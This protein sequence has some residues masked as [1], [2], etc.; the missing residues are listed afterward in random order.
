[1]DTTSPLIWRE[2]GSNQDTGQSWG[3]LEPNPYY[4]PP[5]V[6][7]APPDPLGVWEVNPAGDYRRRRISWDEPVGSGDMFQLV[8]HAGDDR[9]KVFWRG[10][11]AMHQYTFEKFD[12]ASGTWKLFDPGEHDE[13]ARYLWAGVIAPSHTLAVSALAAGTA[14]AQQ[15]LDLLHPDIAGQISQRGWNAA[16]FQ[17][18]DILASPT[19]AKDAAALGI[20][21]TPEQIAA[22]RA[23]LAATTP[24]AQAAAA[25]SGGLGVLGLVVAAVAIAMLAPEAMAL[26]S[27]EGAAA[28]T[29]VAEQAGAGAVAESVAGDAVYSMG[30]DT[31]YYSTFDPVAD[32]AVNATAESVAPQVASETVSE[33]VTTP[34]TWS[35]APQAMEADF[36]PPVMDS[37]A[38]SLPNFSDVPST[39]SLPSTQDVAQ[40]SATDTIS[41]P[42]Q[43][44]A[45]APASTVPQNVPP[46]LPD[47]P[48]NWAKVGST[49]MSAAGKLFQ[50]V[51]KKNSNG[52][53]SIVPQ[54]LVDAQGRPYVI[55]NGQLQYIDPVTG[56]PVP[57]GFLQQMQN[58]SML[59][60]AL[61]IV[62]LL[63]LAS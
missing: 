21:L 40:Q 63:A 22:G 42:P 53:R 59:I 27:G 57:T 19:I 55:V 25:K 13:A 20:V 35:G 17:A 54:R 46:T 47:T 33:I 23:Q 52:Q 30:L 49:V 39:P 31:A 56:Q 43:Q 15:Q 3:V 58:E 9:G 61:A 8:H 51:A 48:T 5:A 14:T 2:T 16:A 18:A 4:I 36:G 26:F 44:V 60:P 32:I 34:E 62:A 11:G 29:V 10:A 28:T 24:A 6:P 7:V 41:A 1:M 37:S 12:I 50:Y 45:N 38:P